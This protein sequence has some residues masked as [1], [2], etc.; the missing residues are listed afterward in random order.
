MIDF[1]AENKIYYLVLVL[2]NNSPTKKL[3]L[4]ILLIP[5]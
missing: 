2:L 5:K 4:E 3:K 1:N